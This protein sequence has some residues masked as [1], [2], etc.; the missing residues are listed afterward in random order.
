LPVKC[1]VIMI[2]RATQKKMMS[3][4][5]TSTVLGRNRSCSTVF[6]GQPSVEKGTRADAVPG[7]QHVLVARQRP[8]VAGRRGAVARFVLAAADV[9]LATR[10]VPGRDLVAPPELAADAPVL[11]VVHPVVVGVD[12]LFGHEAHLAAADGATGLFGDAGAVLAG[13]V[14]GHEPLVGEHGLD[15][16]PGARAARHRQPVL[17]GFHQQA[18]SFQVGHYLLACH[19]PVQAAVGGRGV[20]IDLG[21]QVQHADHGQTVALAHGIVVGVVRRCDLDHAGAEGSGRHRRRQ[22]PG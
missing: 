17:L 16:L 4:P 10:A 11:D 13:L 6:S 22:S 9:Q 3:K 12:P 20:V 18:L 15:H 7:V 1:V 19:E 21:V 8:A 5:V 14:D 2:I